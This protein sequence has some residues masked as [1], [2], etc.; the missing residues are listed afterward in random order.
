MLVARLFCNAFSKTA[1]SLPGA[2]RPNR[3]NGSRGDVR[4]QGCTAS[5]DRS[6]SERKTC[7]VPCPGSAPAQELSWLAT[8]GELRSGPSLSVSLRT[9]PEARSL[10]AAEPKHA[11]AHI[12]SFFTRVKYRAPRLVARV[13]DQPRA[14]KKGRTGAPQ[15]RGRRPRL[16]SEPPRRRAGAS[17]SGASS[18]KRYEA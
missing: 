3:L 9:C 18:R 7:L 13:L 5:E 2:R 8:P 17:T 10:A 14:P 15:K 1:K 4:W 16:K 6:A 11:C 12:R